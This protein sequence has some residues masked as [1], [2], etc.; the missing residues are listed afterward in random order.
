MKK[1]VDEKIK[2]AG[3]VSPDMVLEKIGEVTHELTTKL[4]EKM[5][6]RFEQ[7]VKLVQTPASQWK[8][9]RLGG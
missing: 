4:T 5:D 1:A 3:N 6:Q 8:R 9:L 7:M 2:E